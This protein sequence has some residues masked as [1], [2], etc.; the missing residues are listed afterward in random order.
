VNYGGVSDDLNGMTIEGGFIQ[1]EQNWA[2]KDK[3]FGMG[4]K[5][6]PD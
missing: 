1:F 6:N 3:G 4:N 2:L 5:R